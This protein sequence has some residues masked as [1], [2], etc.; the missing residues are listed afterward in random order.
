MVHAVADPY[1]HARYGPL[2]LNLAQAEKRLG[3]LL[4]GRLEGIHVTERGASPR[5][6]RAVIVGSAGAQ[7]R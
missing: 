3:S 1:D 7:P 5:V 4:K 6:Q 2:T